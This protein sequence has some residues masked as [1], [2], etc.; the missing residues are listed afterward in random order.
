MGIYQ[1]VVLSVLFTCDRCFLPVIFIRPGGKQ[2]AW[3]RYSLNAPVSDCVFIVPERRTLNRVS[4]QSSAHAKLKDIHA[5]SPRV[6]RTTV[7]H[8]TRTI[9][10]AVER[11]S[12][13]RGS[14]TAYQWQAGLGLPGRTSSVADWTTSP[15]WWAGE[16]CS[17]GL[18]TSHR[19]QFILQMCMC[20]LA[21]VRHLH[22]LSFF[23]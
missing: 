3:E 4:K 5:G 18:P 12:P 8:A 17:C 16:M 19:L 7:C 1:P 11:S 6:L 2:A 13:A 14:G 15:L 10:Q 21:V 20:S 23:F 9:W 22:C